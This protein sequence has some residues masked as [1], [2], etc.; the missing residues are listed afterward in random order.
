MNTQ[1]AT[2]SPSLLDHLSDEVRACVVS[3][4]RFRKYFRGATLSLQGEPAR[5][6][7]I[8]Q[9]GWVKLYRVQPDGNEAIMATLSEGQSFDEI[10]ALRGGVSPSSAE[11]LSDTLVMQIDLSAVCSCKNAHHEITA[12]VLSVADAHMA[13][14]RKDIEQMKSRTGAQRLLQYLA[15]L[16]VHQG[17]RT[18]LELPYDKVVLA[19]KLGMRP[20]SLSRAF[21][22]LKSLGVSSHNRQIRIADTAQLHDSLSDM[23]AV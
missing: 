2:R 23:V 18:D 10:E 1:T 4:A 7:K 3:R 11:A 17:D 20:E 9:S 13:A 12:A 8:V 21:G 15:E 5:S 19:G 14:M 22:R 16:S 6:V